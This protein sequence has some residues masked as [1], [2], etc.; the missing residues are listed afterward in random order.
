L[1]HCCPELVRR[2]RAPSSLP[3]HLQTGQH[4]PFMGPLTFA[5]LTQDL[6]TNGVLGD[7]TTADA[8]KGERFLND[9]AAQTAALLRDISV[10]EFAAPA[11]R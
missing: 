1:L 6:S 8:A 11:A 10:F 9:A 3:R 4:P 5:W 7:A 2:D